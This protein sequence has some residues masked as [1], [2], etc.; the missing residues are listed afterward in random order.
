MK[1]KVFLFILLIIS[2]LLNMAQRA[3][4]VLV[5]PENTGEMA[6]PSAIL[7][8]RST[9]KG[10]LLPKLSVSDRDNIKPTTDALTVFI[11]D[12]NEKGFWYFDDFKQEWVQL[13]VVDPNSPGML[14]P[15]GCV[16]M[17]CGSSADFDETGKG[18]HGTEMEGWCLCNGGN[19]TPD[20]TGMFIV[21]YD[22]DKDAYRIPG[23]TAGNLKNNLSKE[24]LPPHIHNLESK[25]NMSIPCTHTHKA[26]DQG[27]DDAPG[28]YR[29]S[30]DHEMITRSNGGKNGGE[31]SRKEPKRGPEDEGT[32]HTKSSEANISLDEAEARITVNLDEE[33]VGYTGNEDITI[34]NRPLYYVLAY[35]IRKE[36]ENENH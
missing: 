18:R 12:D 13:L 9:D 26:L 14:V 35:M 10:V 27:R 16:I 17:Y 33:I 4:G 11:T 6:D 15:Q 19:E 31:F 34:D 21:G 20:L 22:P 28:E 2:P 7:E 29:G 30:H 25:G 23:N 5:S 24:N 32:Y 8:V 1:N 3:G 36:S